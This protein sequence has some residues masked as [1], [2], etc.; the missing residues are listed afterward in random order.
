[1]KGIILAGGTGSRLHPLT[2]AV[3]KQLMPVY[4]KPMIYYPLSILMSAGIREILIISTPSD[5]PQFQSLLG[6]GSQ[7]GCRFEYAVQEVPNGLAQAFVIGADFI[8]NDKVALI[9]GDNIFYGV[10]MDALLKENNNPVGGVV[11]A[12]HVSD[13]ERYGVVEF[14][15]HNQVVSIEEKP[16]QPKSNY[17]V[18]GLYFYDNTVVE[19]AK[20]LQPSARG[21]YEITDVNA[22]YLRRGQLKVAI[23]DRGTAW[24]DTGTFSSLMQAGQFVQVIE[25]RQ[26]LKIGCI[27]EVAYRNG[28]I[29][30]DQLKQLAAGLVK[31][32]YGTYLLQLLH[33]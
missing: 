20:Q 28:F 25:E 18:P 17:A 22:E 14:D 19:I 15:Q 1:M 12:Y 16:Q 13:P 30:D 26:G 21:E 4:D 5:L 24:L 6:D 10:G 33:K 32:G 9:L 31:S 27:E 3:S 29:D 23:L 8:G 2:L 7:L 11:Y